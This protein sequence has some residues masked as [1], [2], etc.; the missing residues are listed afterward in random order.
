MLNHPYI[1]LSDAELTELLRCNDKV[2]FTVIYQKY[3]DKLYL[4][5]Y[6]KLGD[7]QESQD[8]VHELFAQLWH[9]REDIS[10][11]S[12]LMGYLYTGVRNRILD[13]ITHKQVESKYINS[14]QTISKVI[15][16]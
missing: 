16:T 6:Q 14:L 5:A 12:N 11:N 9:K 10:I 8:V 4:H 3:F 2:A 15:I 1:S 13:I 7:K